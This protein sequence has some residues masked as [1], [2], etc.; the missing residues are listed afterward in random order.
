MTNALSSTV[1]SLSLENFT[2]DAAKEA[3]KTIDTNY[4]PMRLLNAAASYQADF[5]IL[6]KNR[7]S[8]DG[9]HSPTSWERLEVVYMTVWGTT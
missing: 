2:D 8:V 7:N 4:H 9:D 5:K 3:A 6:A 1:A